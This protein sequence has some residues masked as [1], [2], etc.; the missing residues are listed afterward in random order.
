MASDH[1]SGDR[2]DLRCIEVRVVFVRFSFQER[3]AGDGVASCNEPT[4]DGLEAKLGP[5]EPKL[6]EPKS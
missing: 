4:V 5:L 6:A 3:R 1:R 2:W